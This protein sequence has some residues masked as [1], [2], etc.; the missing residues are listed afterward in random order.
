MKFIY[1][2]LFPVL[3][4]A[5]CSK[6]NPLDGPQDK[7]PDAA[8][9]DLS[10]TQQ[11]IRG[12]GGVNMPGW[13]PDLTSDQIYKAFGI[14]SGQIGLSILRIR[15]PYDSSK[16]YLEVP[17]A[18]LVKSLGMTIIASPWTPP[19][20]MKSNNNIVGGR[21]DDDAYDDYAAHLK[22]FA[23]YMAENDAPLYAISVQ[24]EPD[25]SVDYESCDW[26]ASQML[27]FTKNNAPSIGIKI[28]VP[29]SYN[30]SRSIS[31]AILNDP[32]GASNISIIGMHI[33]GGS[34]TG[35][36]LAAS[37][38]KEYWMTEHLDTN[39]DWNSVIA[40]A[41][42][43]D[44]C[45]YYGMNA[46][47]WWYIRRFY[48]LIDEDGNVSKRGY[49]MSQYAR[50]IRPGFYRI[51]ATSNPQGLV[52]ATAY[53]SNSKLI[54]VSINEGSSIKQ[55]YIIENGSFNSCTPY[56][57]SGFKNCEKG[58]AILVSNGSFN[59]VLDSSSVTTFVL[60]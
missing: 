35:Y 18:K 45:M 8:Y 48:G 12:F 20:W 59:A 53:K 2:I 41:K 47:I 37:K 23:G 1:L 51:D 3:I 32:A 58:E 55:K 39:T 21:L 44:N 11:L 33:Y 56:T 34:L 42:E 36:P 19:A 14:D 57:T 28:I 17:T 38:G 31:D 30:Q 13:I 46:Y 10:N 25:V 5:G 15:V 26:N 52:F 6:E 27:K 29:E 60:D 7:I 50:F 9:I 54:I 43:I 16:F 49:V 24:N 40:T 4:I 22:S